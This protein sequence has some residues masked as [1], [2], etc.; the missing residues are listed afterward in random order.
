MDYVVAGPENGE[1]QLLG[2]SAT[3]TLRE[4]GEVDLRQVSPDIVPSVIIIY[5]EIDLTR[6]EDSAFSFVGEGQLEMQIALI[7]WVEG[8][9]RPIEDQARDVLGF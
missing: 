9:Y 5:S 7:F 1:E 2:K 3:L 6:F 4:L 8:N